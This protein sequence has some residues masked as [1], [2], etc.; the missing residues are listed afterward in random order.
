ME[1]FRQRVAYGTEGRVFKNWECAA[2]LNEAAGDLP[3]GWRC[4]QQSWRAT[5]HKKNVDPR[6]KT[7]VLRSLLGWGL[8]YGFQEDALRTLKQTWRDTGMSEADARMWEERLGPSSGRAPARP[9]AGASR[10]G[11]GGRATRARRRAPCGPAV[12]AAGRRS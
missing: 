2:V 11:R 3:A 6:K 7:Q 4:R 12:R 5:Q 1:W 9:R 8:R 10:D